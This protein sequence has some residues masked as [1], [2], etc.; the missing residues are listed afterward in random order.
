VAD[1]PS[2]KMLPTHLGLILD[3]NRRWARSEGMPQL[4]GHRLGYQNLHPITVHA[5]DRG[6][7]FVSAYVFS[8][9]NWNR[10]Q[11]EVSYLMDLVV[12]VSRHEVKKYK[13]DGIRI[14]FLGS[15]VRLSA[16]V[17][18]AVESA[19][20]ETKDNTRGTLA[21]CLN[22]G[23]HTEIAEG[24]ARMIQDGV[25]PEDVTPEKVA[26]YLYHPE[27]PPCDLII[28]T[29]GEMRLSNFMLWRAAYAELYF[30]PMP[31]PAY[32]PEDLDLALEEYSGRQRRLG[33]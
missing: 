1:A 32:T 9:E 22:Y 3:G 25:R 16:K 33:K 10:T 7:K 12:W 24:V 21:L 19:E 27:L 30:A 28:R 18:D 5:V 29:S 20:D 17:L 11:E 6:V 31:W 2:G 8:T 15:R 23:G 4:E 26:D 14:V 13:K